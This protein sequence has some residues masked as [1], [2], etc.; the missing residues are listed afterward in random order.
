MFIDLF[1]IHL[2]NALAY[3]AQFLFSLFLSP[4]RFLVMYF[5]WT[6]VFA[7]NGGAL[8]GNYDLNQLIFYSIFITFIY[9][10]TWNDIPRDIEILIRKGDFVQYLLK[11]IQ[12][13]YYVFIDIVAKRF[14]ALIIEVLPLL[15]IFALFF[16]SYFIVGNILLFLISMIFA[17]LFNYLFGMG[18]GLLAFWF[19]KIRTFYW[20]VSIF[21][22]FS[23]G[24]A[25]PLTL[26]P[27]LLF[28]VFNFLPF[29]FM[30][31]IPIQIYLNKYNNME[32]LSLLWQALIWLILLTIL[33]YFVWIRAQKRYCGEGT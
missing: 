6:A 27:P 20:A 13:T 31:F 8:I 23:S 22:D 30:S 26:F 5:I 16:K 25:L 1:K 3:R 15:I 4:F 24:N 2:K 9:A 19:V 32:L 10:V 21:K 29:K 12:Y 14:L 33:V 28:S 17:F 11:P 18:V 7:N